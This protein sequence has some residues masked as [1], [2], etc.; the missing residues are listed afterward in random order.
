MSP[1]TEKVLE[2]LTQ[3]RKCLTDAAAFGGPHEDSI[4]DLGE[5]IDDLHEEIQEDAE[6][7]DSDNDFE[8]DE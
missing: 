5:E 7:A 2:L 8:D 6:R 1:N 4:E 3:A